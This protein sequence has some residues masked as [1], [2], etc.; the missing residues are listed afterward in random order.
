MSPRVGRNR[1]AQDP[2]HTFRIAMLDRATLLSSAEAR[3]MN[4]N[5]Y[6]FEARS[7]V[8][9]SGSK[10]KKWTKERLCGGE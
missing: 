4:S 7:L 3:V 6:H 10:D 2:P 9:D 8:Q 1:K 5:N